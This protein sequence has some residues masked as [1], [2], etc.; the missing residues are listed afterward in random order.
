MITVYISLEDQTKAKEIAKELLLNKLVAEI[1]IDFDNHVFRLNEKEQMEEVVT[2]LISVYTK[3]ILFNEIIDFTY[4][5]FGNNI[6]IYSVP[7]TQG[8]LTLSNKIRNNT[9]TS[10]NVKS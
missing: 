3:A 7:I 10:E 9:K 4:K 8:N 6:T 5:R 2:T 1:S